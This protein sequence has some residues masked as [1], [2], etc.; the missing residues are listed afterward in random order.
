MSLASDHFHGCVSILG[1]RAEQRL[2]TNKWRLAM[3]TWLVAV[4]WSRRQTGATDWSR[5]WSRPHQAPPD[6]VDSRG[7]VFLLSHGSWCFV[8][9]LVCA[10]KQFVVPGVTA[11][12]W[13]LTRNGPGGISTMTRAL[14][15][16]RPTITCAMVP[17]CLG[18][19]D[20][21]EGS[22]IGLPASGRRSV[23][24]LLTAICP[25]L[26]RSSAPCSRPGRMGPALPAER[27]LTA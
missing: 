15:A 7:P 10:W 27:G 6:F 8:L 1:T 25:R 3:E 4:D 2:P 24:T 18:R 21:T 14:T 20:P 11:S 26:M 17:S 12:E 13:I 19:A 5:S 9:G 16:E 23:A 22:R